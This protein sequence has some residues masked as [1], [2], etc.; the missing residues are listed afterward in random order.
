LSKAL[1]YGPTAALALDE[2]MASRLGIGTWRY[3]AADGRLAITGCLALHLLGVDRVDLQ[4]G[5]FL[6][7]LSGEAAGR[8]D[9]L[10][11]GTTPI[12]SFSF[13][14]RGHSGEE[15]WFRFVGADAASGF[16]QRLGSGDGRAMVPSRPWRLRHDLEERL[17]L[18]STKSQPT[19]VL[20]LVKIEQLAL[21]EQSREH[22]PSL[23]D[24]ITE[25]LARLPGAQASYR[26]ESDTIALVLVNGD[27][28]GHATACAGHALRS[29]HRWALPGRIRAHD[30]PS[31]RRH[32]PM[33]PPP[34]PSTSAPRSSLAYASEAVRRA[35]MPSSPGGSPPSSPTG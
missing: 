7:R 2:A 3:Q 32:P 11:R 31:V 4:L 23:A 10:L 18:R 22:G 25:R 9:A 34:K 21:L 26:L 19:T 35:G 24:T 12:D 20:L 28:S 33:P 30:E 13:R 5:S 6:D 14:S 15:V 16:V 8:L 17:A 1:R 27:G 29:V